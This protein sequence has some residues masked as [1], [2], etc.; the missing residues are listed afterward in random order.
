MLM[1]KVYNS[2]QIGDVFDR[3]GCDKVDH[4]YH[5]LYQKVFE[6]TKPNDDFKLMEVGIWK[7]N[8]ILAWRRLFKNA[9][10]LGL[11][12][13]QHPHLTT[14]RF[15]DEKTDLVFA[16][17]ASRRHRSHYKYVL[18]QKFDFI[19]DDGDHA[20]ATQMATFLL[21]RRQFNEVYIIEDIVGQY[22]MEDIKTMVEALGYKTYVHFSDRYMGDDDG[23]QEFYA[24]AIA[25]PGS[26]FGNAHCK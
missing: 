6:N 24:I 26:K 8:S 4:K 20:I 1:N 13:E 9:Y 14:S 19:I 3:A 12:I 18:G 25:H 16:N 21:Y 5:D 10:I 22:E 23:D 11:D 17:S 7:G 2:Q 15:A